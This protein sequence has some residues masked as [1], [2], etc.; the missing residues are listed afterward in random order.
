M[1]NGTAADVIAEVQNV[2]DTLGPGG[3]LLLCTNHTVQSTPRAFDN[4]IAYYFAAHR[5]SGYP[6]GKKVSQN[7]SVEGRAREC[8]TWY[9]RC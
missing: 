3:G 9:D 8:Y 7:K 4:T 6:L 5:F 1:S 2:I